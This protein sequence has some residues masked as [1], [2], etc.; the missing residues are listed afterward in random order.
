M[1][2]ST[3][4]GA[5]G[6]RAHGIVPL[7]MKEIE[8]VAGGKAAEMPQSVWERLLAWMEGLISSPPSGSGRYFITG[9]QVIILQQACIDAGNNFSA[10]FGSG[11]GGFAVRV[12]GADADM[13]L[14]SINC[15]RP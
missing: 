2:T 11:S 15:T 5:N 12:V 7:S 9:D 4:N 13:S 6:T 10:T 8:L 3:L 14:V 1:E